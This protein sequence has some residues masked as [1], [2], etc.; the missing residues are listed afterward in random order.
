M[1]KIERVENFDEEQRR[2]EERLRSNQFAD[3]YEIVITKKG[4]DLFESRREHVVLTEDKD[5]NKEYGY[6]PMYPEIRQS[7][8][9]TIL[10]QVINELDI[11]AVVKAV[12]GIN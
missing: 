5:G 4:Y 8:E 2:L 9:K 1:T 10:K 6:S 7:A 12:N 11:T 3:V